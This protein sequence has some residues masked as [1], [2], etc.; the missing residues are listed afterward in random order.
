[1]SFLKNNAV[2]NVRLPDTYKA[3]IERYAREHGLTP[4]EWARRVLLCALA[5]GRYEVRH[6]KTD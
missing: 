3:E 5:H 2:M 6:P 1:M 4:S